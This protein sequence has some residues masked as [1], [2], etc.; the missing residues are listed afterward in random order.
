M[1]KKILIAN[2]GE[3]AVRVIQ[4]CRDMG[5][6][7]VAVYSE[8]DREALHAQLADESICIGPA[9]AKDSYLNMD[10]IITAAL[11]VGAD[12]IHP[13][14]GFLSENAVFARKC[15]EAGIVFIGPSPE[16]MEKMGDKI[17]ARE[18]AL[19]A[20]APV[21]PGSHGAVGSYEEAEAIAKEIGFPV[22]IKASAGGG[23]RGIRKV[24]RMEDLQ[25]HFLSAAAEAEAAFG[26]GS[27]YIEKFVANPRHIEFQILADSFGTVVH[28]FERECSIQ[29][30]HQKLLEESPSPFLDEELR[31]KMGAS[32][33]AIAK[34][35]NYCNA[36]TIEFLVDDNRNYYFCEMN[37]RIQ[38]EHP[39]TESV[40]GVDLV[41]EQIRIAAGEPISFAQE[42][43][44]QRGHA[45]ECR[46]N[47]EDYTRDFMPCPGTI[48]GLHTPSGPGVRVDSAVYQGCT[49]SPFYDSMLSKLIV[50]GSTR[51]QAIARMKR[52]LAEYLFEG[53]ITNIDFQLKII[54]TPEFIAGDYDTGFIER[55]NLLA[56]S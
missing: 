32:A 48:I 7:S 46:I 45:I 1:F 2:R 37:T 35:C 23:G 5:I 54:D 39:V 33:I 44:V 12:A 6:I 42:D 20:G 16:T 15:Q 9:R 36:G 18:T 29:R 25:H 24:D 40:T 53:I 21:V 26:D 50:T 47:A 49:V 56:K 43:I 3:I 31:Q 4:A 38:V 8:A 55:S 11:G 27:L 30:R 22:M 17:A 28:L 34:A 14:F 19:K 41:V 51:K 13:G 10:N 52:A